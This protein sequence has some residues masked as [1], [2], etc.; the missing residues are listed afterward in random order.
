M[1]IYM[2]NTAAF[3]IS[4]SIHIWNTIWYKKLIW[5]CH[6]E[7][8]VEIKGFMWSGISE[9]NVVVILY[10]YEYKDIKSMINKSKT[11]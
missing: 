8:N 1:G 11:K 3:K 7:K 2:K 4:I 6:S 9:R 10:L 5:I